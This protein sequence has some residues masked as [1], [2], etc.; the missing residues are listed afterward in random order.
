MQI[1]DQRIQAT[2]IE[3]I[4]G[5]TQDWDDIEHDEAICLD[6]QLVEDLGFSSIDFIQLVVAIEEQYE[7]KLGFHDLL[8]H[9][10][11]YVDDLRV[12][13][14]A[15]FV[16]GRLSGRLTMSS[17]LVD[18]EKSS[19][20]TSAVSEASCITPEQFTDFQAIIDQKVAQFQ[21]PIDT[22]PSTPKNKR[23][24]FVLSPPRS[25]STLL[26]ILLAGHSR[27]FAPPE[28]HLLTYP[29]LAKRKA[30][31]NGQFTSHLLQ[32]AIRSVMQLKQCSAESAQQFVEA[33]ENRDLSTQQ[34]YSLLQ[35][36]MPEEQMLVDKTPTYAM[37]LNILNRAEANFDRPLYI[38]LIRHPYGMAYSYE[39][40]KLERI[41]PMTHQ[42]QFSSRELAEMTWTL[43]HKN[44]LSFLDQIP[45]ER[46]HSL[47]FEN[48]V[49]HPETQLKKLCEFLGVEFSADMLE[50]Y[51]NQQQRM[52]DGV[53]VAS[54]MSGDLKFH[55]HD[56]INPDVAYQWRQFHHENFL[57]Q[58]TW[59]VASTFGYS[60]DD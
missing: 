39:R 3:I 51:Q 19:L 55:L 56:R 52:I 28:L 16:E 53:Q 15:E 12:N 43:S 29:T 26:R 49:Q 54:E 23:A 24:V 42:G 13:D 25:G 5:I 38:H 18:V 47:H 8:M 46:Y 44:I 9:N 31:L 7:R 27:L 22:P 37:H 50:P 1:L 33:A 57:S 48:L 34:F 36:W 58:M 17:P 11:Q 10:G 6:S 30:A 32:G 20:H 14:L 2:I 21:Q 60:Q 40:S 41:A 59:D 35:G 45:E 4:E